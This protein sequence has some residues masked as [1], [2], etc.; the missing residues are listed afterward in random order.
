MAFSSKPSSRAVSPR[1]PHAAPSEYD[2]PF[3]EGFRTPKGNAS[4]TVLSDSNTAFDPPVQDVP[5]SSL[6]TGVARDS[7]H[8]LP[9]TDRKKNRYIPL[10]LRFPIAF[11]VPLTM[12]LLA[13]ALEAG[14]I[15]SNRNQGFSVPTKNAIS[16]ASA[17]FLLS[18]VP[19]LFVIGPA[20][21]YRELDWHV[22][23]YQPYVVM[24][25]GD[26][27]AE[28]SVL[29]D[30]VTLGPLLSFI[31]SAKFKHR[32]ITWSTIT[33]LVTYI[34]QPLA[35]SMFQLQ[36]NPTGSGVQ[37]QSIRA[38]GLLDFSDLT[39]FV[40][41]AGFAEAAVFNSLPDPPFI[42]GGWAI[43][44]FN[45]PSN[46]YLNGTLQ[47]NTTGIQTSVNCK[48][49]NG[50][51]T[52]TPISGGF[53][54]TSTSADGCT[55]SAT[56]SNTDVASQQYGVI[57]VPD[58]CST[59]NK[60]QRPVMFWFFH[61]TSN[62]NGSAEART[63]FCNPTL[64]AF[65]VEA[66]ANLNNDSVTHV[67]GLNSNVPSNNVTGQFGN[68]PLNGVIFENQTDPFIQ[69]RAIATNNG[70]PG[71]I[72]R[73]A[74][75]SS[76]GADAEFEKPNSFVDLTSQVYTQFLSLVAKSIYFVPQDN[77][78][79]AQLVSINPRLLINNLP[80]HALAI[81]LFFI[82][83]AGVFL[84]IINR[85]QRRGLYLSTPPGTIAA[86]I[87]MTSHSGFGE[88]L[89]PYDDEE[90]LQNKLSDLRFSID[91]RTGAIVATAAGAARRESRPP[92]KPTSASSYQ[93]SFMDTKR[94]FSMEAGVV[95][96]GG[97]RDEALE[98]LLGGDAGG[99]GG[100][101]RGLSETSDS[102]FS[103]SQA[104][105]E[106]ASGHGY[107]PVRSP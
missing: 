11:G 27:R 71:A 63:V 98:S 82:G 31:N 40:A 99:R 104:A 60:T 34:L 96:R 83:F 93:M 38:I 42:Q 24:S 26:A 53:T 20:W 66:T 88:L 70:V 10:A 94:P 18:F 9:T 3:T 65:N 52:L 95:G 74:S 78:L 103:S 79:N 101:P 41:S 57:E 13:I 28:E 29:L 85:R 16:F 62:G 49:P 15:I 45:F 102:A 32:V 12:I 46:D 81:L 50:T 80:G 92:L 56:A 25:K 59:L 55:Q 75:Q 64:E 33:A 23:W 48:G 107:P 2:D 22:R 4:T 8:L 21:V 1:P 5:S 19:T 35:G 51:P 36:N 105:F 100:L 47:V 68:S 14:I 97:E 44:Q 37:V 76:G 86:T 39:A 61:P 90:T 30:Y 87:A 6:R 69:A 84:H 72:F 73:F 43:S 77:E 58:S 106:A 67:V 7:T 54:I 89:M 91:R 17:Q